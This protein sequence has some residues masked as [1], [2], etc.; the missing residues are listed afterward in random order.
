VVFRYATESELPP[1]S[2]PANDV[3]ELTGVPEEGDPGNWKPASPDVHGDA[4]AFVVYPGKAMVVGLTLASFTPEAFLYFHLTVNVS[5]AEVASPAQSS[6]DPGA[7]MVWTSLPFRILLAFV[8][9]LDP[10]V[11]HFFS[12]ILIVVVSGAVPPFTSGGLKVMVPLIPV[13][14]VPILPQLTEP[15]AVSVGIFLTD[16]DAL[17]APAARTVPVTS[18]RAAAPK[19]N[20]RKRTICSS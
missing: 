2:E 17:A 10:V 15:V 3:P 13:T 4:L 6:M 20:L 18:A 14:P 11:V 9:T 1:V 7:E 8:A 19:M 12:L 16:A 5:G